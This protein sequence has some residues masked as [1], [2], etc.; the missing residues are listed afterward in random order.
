MT[1]KKESLL[2]VVENNIP[3]R[4]TGFEGVSNKDLSYITGLSQ[5]HIGQIVSK[6]LTQGR[7]C[8]VK[9]SR[10]LEKKKSIYFKGTNCSN[11]ESVEKSKTCGNCQRFTNLYRC[12]LLDCAYE[13]H[14][15]FDKELLERVKREMLKPSTPACNFHDKR[16][17]GQCKTKEVNEFL[18]DNIDENF[19][20]HC[21]IE[22]CRKPI[23]ELSNALEILRLGTTTYYCPHC[24]SPI[25]LVYGERWNRYEFKYWDARFDIFQRDFRK[26]TGLFLANRKSTTNLGISLHKK[27]F[28][29]IDL[30]RKFIL[31]SGLP[32]TSS[33][34]EK[35]IYFPLRKLNYI[36]CN[37]WD[38]YLDVKKLHEVINKQTGESRAL[39]EKIT[40]FEPRTAPQSVEPSAIEVGGN[41]IFIATKM[42]N[43]ISLKANVLSREAVLEA[44]SKTSTKEKEVYTKARKRIRDS[45]GALNIPRELD[46]SYWNQ[47]EGGMGFL[48][49][50]PFK[51]EVAKYKFF[52][53]PRERG[54]N[55]RYESF[56]P[57]GLDYA[58]SDFHSAV[59]GVN[60]IVGNKLK[61]LV[62]NALGFAHD[63]FRGWCHRKYTKGL[64]YDVHELG[65]F[66]SL[67]F[68]YFAIIEERLLPSHFTQVRGKRYDLLYCLQPGSEGERIIKEIS[69]EVLLAKVVLLNDKTVTVLQAYKEFIKLLQKLFT[70]VAL[71]T[72]NI[73][74]NDR[75]TNKNFAIWKILQETKN[76]DYLSHNKLLLLK[77]HI[78]K[79]LRDE[80]PFLPLGVQ[81][82]QINA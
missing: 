22:R 3:Q 1:L 9:E 19:V 59:N 16:E 31:L 13:K 67:L 79:F 15:L 5:S 60:R 66:I 57:F 14:V 62:Y 74:I 82:V 54:R 17:N 30:K 55:V 49:Y 38:D 52:A 26:L 58:R 28:H 68:T 44:A 27:A 64:F 21:P 51:K 4:I 56:K 71:S 25:K 45:F 34:L 80:I 2:V 37:R 72:A 11:T 36:S 70:S 43:P 78:S 8:C 77:K 81:E 33:N 32:I 48:M 47:I 75:S 46:F 29:H 6:L 76:P 42:C 53:P 23:S 35:A 69:N 65:K 63:G 61:E 39:Y 18:R 7:I 50:E 20:L 40:I 10:G 24:G 73:L 12:A 41:E